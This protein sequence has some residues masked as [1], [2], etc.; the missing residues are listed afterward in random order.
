MSTPARPRPRELDGI[1][2]LDKPA[3]LSSNDALQRVKRLFKARKA[4]HTGNLD[5]PATGLLPLCFGEASTVC[6]FLLDAAK[7]YVSVFRLGARTTTGDAAGEILETASLAGVTRPR[8][9]EVLGRYT[10]DI[11]QIPPM[12]SAIKRDGQPLY[13]LAHRGLSVER[14]ARPVRIHTLEL[15]ALRSDEMEV[16]VRCSKGT[17][18][19]TLAE[20]IGAE[21]GCLAHVAGLRRTEVGVYALEDALTLEQMEALAARGTDALDAR[22]LGMDTALA[23]EPD[24]ALSDDASYYLRQGQPVLVP[25]APTSGLVRIYDRAHQFL[26]IGQVLDDGRIAPRRLIKQP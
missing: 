12:H 21:L 23:R 20:D 26:G 5:L 6:G 7:T 13:K 2:L 14:T 22:L 25:H 19:R 18:I 3:G 24:V 11:L 16:R 4:G 15:L 1:V 17:Y 10:G 9:E 8:V